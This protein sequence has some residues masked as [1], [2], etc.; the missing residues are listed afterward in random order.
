MWRK[1]VPLDELES[2]YRARFEYFARVASAIT[3]NGESGRDAVQNAFA[4]AIR[5]RA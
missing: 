1:G 2:L 3:G 4:S 5:R